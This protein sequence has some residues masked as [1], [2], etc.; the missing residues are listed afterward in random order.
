MKRGGVGG[1]GEGEV[2]GRGWGRCARQRRVL[3]NQLITR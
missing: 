2:E 1:G 3:A